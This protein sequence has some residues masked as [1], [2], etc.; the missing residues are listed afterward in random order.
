M[1]SLR[2]RYKRVRL[3]LYNNSQEHLLERANCYFHTTNILT[4]KFKYKNIT[5]WGQIDPILVQQR[6]IKK[7][8][9]KKSAIERPDLLPFPNGDENGGY[10]PDFCRVVFGEFRTGQIAF[11]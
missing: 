5:K 4:Q 8:L 3:Y 10:R 11:N 9:K 2:T 6:S 1:L 7:I